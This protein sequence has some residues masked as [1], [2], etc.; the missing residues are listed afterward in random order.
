METDS[1]RLK[2]ISPPS[3]YL[4]RAYLVA[5]REMMGSAE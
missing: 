2:S 4:S 1:L 3:L 5:P